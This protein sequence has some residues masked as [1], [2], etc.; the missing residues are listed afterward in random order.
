MI[1]ILLPLA[2]IAT[3]LFAPIYSETVRG[4]E[5]GARASILTG[6]DY[7][8]PTLD[9][10]RQGAFSLEDKCEPKGELR[11]KLIFAAIF[12]SG[13]AAA[14]GVLG[15]FPVVSKLTSMV[16]MLA[17]AVVVAAIGYYI[18]TQIGG[19]DGLHAV[20]WGS[21][22]AGGGGLLTLISGLSGMRGR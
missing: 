8:G 6:Y 5:L 18:L 17:G 2:I 11:G 21:Y 4:S 19:E 7:V 16:T 9:C 13:V 14:I 1:R 10:W 20:Q 3:L 15:L 12:V 22:L